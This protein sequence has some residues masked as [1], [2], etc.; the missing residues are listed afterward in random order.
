MFAPS[1]RA[2]FGD[3]S[4]AERLGAFADLDEYALLHQAA[5]W[6][7]GE[8]VSAIPSPGDGTVTRDVADGWRAIL[9]RRP[10]WRAEREVRARVGDARL[11]G[12]RRWPSSATRE[13]GGVVLDLDGV[14]AR[15]GADRPA[16]ARDRAARRRARPVARGGARQA[17]G[18]AADRPPVP[19]GGLIG[20]LGRAVGMKRRLTRDDK[21]A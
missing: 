10:R 1:I 12:R 20:G 3:G 14:D 2:V 4:P 9:L 13:P 7:R 15:P 8:H 19:T 18:V 17:A 11:A 16:G 6:A 21:G 5:L